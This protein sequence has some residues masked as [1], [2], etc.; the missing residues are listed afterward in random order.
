MLTFFKF[1]VH[2]AH[3][4]NFEHE[5]CTKRLKRRKTLFS[6]CESKLNRV[7]KMLLKRLP[8]TCYFYI[9]LVFL[10]PI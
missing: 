2:T 9:N 3:F 4:E 10:Q 5:D 1:L 7:C 6:K 8:E